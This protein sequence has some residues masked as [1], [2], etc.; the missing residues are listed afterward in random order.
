MSSFLM[1]PEQWGAF[2]SCH[3]FSHLRMVILQLFLC[4]PVRRRLGEV[5]CCF[6]SEYQVACSN[7]T[8]KL[9]GR[10]RGSHVVANR[11]M[12]EERMILRALSD[13]ARFRYEGARLSGGIQRL[14]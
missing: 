13:C 6:A 2:S 7:L 3:S 11:R 1:K 5:S 10:R 4:L 9:P 14:S 8:L 12:D